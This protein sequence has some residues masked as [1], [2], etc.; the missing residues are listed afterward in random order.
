DGARQCDAGGFDLAGREPAAV[1]D[2]Q[3]VV[4]ERERRTPPRRPFPA[5]LLHLAVF[6]FFRCEHGGR[7][8]GAGGDALLLLLLLAAEHLAAEDPHPHADDPVRGAGLREAVVDVGAQRMQR[9]PP[10]AIPLGARDLGPAQPAGRLDAHALGAHAH[11]P[12]QR[13]LRRTR[14]GDAAFELE[15]DVLRDQ[16]RVDVGP[17]DLVDVDEGLLA[18]EPRQLLLE[19][20]DL[21]ALLADHDARP[22]GV[23]VDLGLV[24]RALDV[25]LRDPRMVQALLQE[26]ADLDVLVEEVRVLPTGEPARIPRLDDTAAE[27]L[28]M[29]LLSHAQA[30]A[31]FRR[32]STTTV[33]G[34]LRLKIGVAGPC[35]GGVKRFPVGPSST[36]ARFT[37]SASTSTR[38]PCSAFATADLS[39]FDTNRA[40]PLGLYSGIPSAASPDWPRIKSTTRRA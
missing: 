31:P 25:D 40:P 17:A 29:D 15:R 9:H 2:L 28:R 20:L 14:E 12:G 7:E 27:P 5:P 19:L 10:F 30:S 38:W 34:L 4:A 23:D 16:L 13:L 21:R 8:S 26:V 18:G 39:V 3:P 11:G 6:D 1:G 33:M 24:G 36:H 35:A 22:R 37:Y 32:S